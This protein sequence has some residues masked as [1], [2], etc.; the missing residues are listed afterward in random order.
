MISLSCIVCYFLLENSNI[1]SE[2]VEQS[3]KGRYKGFVMFILTGLFKYGILINR[4]MHFCYSEF[5]FSQR[6]NIKG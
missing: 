4:N 1:I 3:N 6:K 2:L 5:S